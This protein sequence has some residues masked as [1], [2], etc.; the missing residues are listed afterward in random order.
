MVQ[1]LFESKLD[2]SIYFLR[3]G[4]RENILDYT[5]PETIE[6]LN[7]FVAPKAVKVVDQGAGGM[8]HMF[9]SMATA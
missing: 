8:K 7:S 1:K 5:K 4:I 9:L 3:H 6:T 2:L